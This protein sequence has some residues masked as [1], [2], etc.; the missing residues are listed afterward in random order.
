M[1]DMIQ[2]QVR[3][4]HEAQ[5]TVTDVN[6]VVAEAGDIPNPVLTE[7]QKAKAERDAKNYWNGMITRKE[8]REKI[9]EAVDPFR[10]QAQMLM[11][12]NLSLLGILSE[13]GIA[14]E[15]EINNY[16][17]KVMEDIYGPMDTKEEAR[18]DEES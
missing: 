10:Q 11:V 4:I 5:K 13:K 3:A 2:A 16:S 17:I 6:K 7:K 15:E 8:A 14:T 18:T 12:Q 9:Q 1:E